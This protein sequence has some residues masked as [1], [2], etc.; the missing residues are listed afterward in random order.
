MQNQTFSRT[1]L[2]TFIYVDQLFLPIVFANFRYDYLPQNFGV[3]K[4]LLRREFGPG[5]SRHTDQL[6][7]RSKVSLF[8]AIFD[9]QI[10]FSY[11]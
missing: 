8:L 10:P 9:N 6:F 2:T 3:L 1:T 7:L 11:L 4:A 5:D